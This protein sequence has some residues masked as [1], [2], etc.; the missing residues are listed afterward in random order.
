MKIVNLFL[1]FVLCLALFSACKKEDEKETTPKENLVNKSWIVTDSKTEILL[2]FGQTLPDSIQNAFDPTQQLK[3][4]IITFNENGTFQVGT[5]ATQQGN[6]TLS[7]DGKKI[8][9]TGLVEGDL[10][11]IIDAQTLIKLQTFEVTTLTDTKLGIQ[12]STDVPIPAEVTE[13]LIGIA[14]PINV[15]VKLNITFDKQ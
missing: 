6:W 8:T 7:E 5:D 2:P 4:Q 11:Q 13:Q 10:T 3:G 1:V 9:F 12:N 14:I 15:T